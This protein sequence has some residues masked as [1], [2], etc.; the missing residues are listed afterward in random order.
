M[1]LA[2]AS[3]MIACSAGSVHAWWGSTVYAGPPPVYYSPVYSTYYA[4]VY[5]AYYAPVYTAYYTPMYVV[6]YF[7]EP[8]YYYE[9]WVEYCP[10]LPLMVTPSVAVE[11][12]VPARMPEQAPVP[13]GA[14]AETPFSPILP[15]EEKSE[16]KLPKQDTPLNTDV[17][18][19]DV[20]K[21]V[22][23]KVDAP[24]L[25]PPKL[26]LPKLEPLTPKGDAPIIELPSAAAP[27]SPKVDLPLPPITVNKITSNFRPAPRGTLVPVDG[28]IPRDGKY[29]VGF[30][31]M[32]ERD[33]TLVVDGQEIKLPKRS[34][35]S[36]TVGSTFRWGLE[37]A[38]VEDAAIPVTAAGAEI[39]IR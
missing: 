32:S 8:L 4:P 34:S 11:P 28:V 35:V 26:E 36:A 23:P 1:R 7:V 30:F 33:V 6:P 3:L 5:S 22:L 20:P 24:K 13:K 39:I 15:V 2:L 38:E 14:K 18:K 19:F 37:S 27:N 17:P 16:S 9:P 29:R 25:P 12:P 10:C 31:N 21:E